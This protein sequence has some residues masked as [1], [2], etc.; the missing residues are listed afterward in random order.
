M[1]EE[2]NQVLQQELQDPLLSCAMIDQG[3]NS[4]TLQVFS[5]RHGELLVKRYVDDGRRRLETEYMALKFLSRKGL[6][7]ARPLMARSA[8]FYA[9]Y[10]RLPGKHPCAE[11]A[12][13]RI[14]AQLLDFLRQLHGFRAELPDFAPAADACLSAGAAIAL[15]QD[16]RQQL[17]GVD[18]GRLQKFLTSAFDPCCELLSRR[19]QAAVGSAF[20][21]ALPETEQTLSPSDFGLHNA[22][23]TADGRLSFV[24]FEYFGRDD[25][26]KLVSDFLWHPSME[27]PAAFRAS[28][29]QGCRELYGESFYQRWQDSHAIHGL[30]WV[31]LLLNE[32]LPQHWQRRCFAGEKA[33]RQQRQ[34]YQLEK[35]QSLLARL[36]VLEKGTAD[37]C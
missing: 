21:E 26:A 6:P 12:D 15:V 30:K 5:P 13:T 4:R 22:L 28:F 23:C 36:E 32:F 16:R 31:L 14:L 19:F 20:F 24:D 11:K 17:A 27:L 1:E 18:D 7:V 25:P 34:Q 9:V 29:L 33:S 2:L 37:E 10:S 3:S 8:E 35:A